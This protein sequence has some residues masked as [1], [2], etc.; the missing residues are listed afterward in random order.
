MA[1]SARASVVKKNHRQL[2]ATIFGPAHDARTARLSAKLQELAAKPKPESVKA[3]DVDD[4]TQENAEEQSNNDNSEGALNT[5]NKKRQSL[6]DAFLPDM[7][8]DAQIAKTKPG[9][10]TSTKDKFN[11]K[12]H[13]ISKRKKTRNSIVFPSEIARRK[14]MAGAKS[15]R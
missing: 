5:A 12:S 14:K 4:K 8:L 13:K 6:T 9:K 15:K 3:M 2:R 1:K 10:T 11:H 7:D